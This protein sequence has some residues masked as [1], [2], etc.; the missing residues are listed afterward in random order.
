MPIAADLQALSHDA[1]VELFQLSGYNRQSPSESFYFVNGTGVSFGG[2]AYN[3]LACAISGVEY[4][5]E[6]S[7]PRPRLTVADTQRI[8][9]GLVYFYGGI[10]GSQLTLRKTLKRY[11]DGGE[12]ADAS[13]IKSVDI[14]QVSQ[15]T[16]EIPGQVI[17]WE[18]SSPI[19]LTSEVLP[20][21]PLMRLCSWVYR[22]RDGTGN[23]PYTGTAMFTIDN[24]RTLD[25]KLDQCGKTVTSC[26]KRFGN[27]VLPFGGMP[28]LVR[29]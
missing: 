4:T 29:S 25:P 9:S 28:G 14:W 15:C 3:P 6:G 23:C 24:K 5:G 22:S 2:I 27:T 8:I 20:S 13:A 18:L 19:D 1:E 17:E 10:E 26:T 12:A 11:L 16:K 21:R 7:L